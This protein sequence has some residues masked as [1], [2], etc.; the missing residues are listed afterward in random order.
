LS[1]V[2]VQESQSCFLYYE[3]EILPH[4]LVVWNMSGK[5][6]QTLLMQGYK[7]EVFNRAKWLCMVHV[8]SLS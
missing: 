3:I 4:F 2:L 7:Y 8:L 1:D 5:S 6:I